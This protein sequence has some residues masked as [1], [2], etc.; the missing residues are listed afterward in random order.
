[1]S[2]SGLIY[3]IRTVYFDVWR[4]ILGSEQVAKASS[5]ACIYTMLWN[6]NF[7][8]PSRKGLG[9]FSNEQF[10]EPCVQQASKK[11]RRLLDDGV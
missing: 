11:E 5:S 2:V 4:I 6:G 7:P 9:T 10:S 8:S 1:M 3:E